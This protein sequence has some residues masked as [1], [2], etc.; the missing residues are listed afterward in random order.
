M[1]SKGFVIAIVCQGKISQESKDGIVAIPFMS[2]YAIRLRNKN[3]RRAVAFVRVDDE[4]VGNIVV[5]ANSF[6]DLECPVDTRKNFK[7]VS[8][9]SGE[10]VDFGKNNK[11]DGSNGV[12]RVEWK[13]ERE[14]QPPIYT[15]HFNSG[16]RPRNWHAGE[17]FNKGIVGGQMRS[18]VPTS[19][20]LGFMDDAAP[21]SEG[22]TV[23]GRNSSQSFRNTHVD[24]EAGE[25][26]IIQLVLKGFQQET[27]VYTCHNRGCPKHT[28]EFNIQ[29]HFCNKCGNR[30][31]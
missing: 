6:V 21:R 9:D 18:A 5:N 31:A 16:N 27:K 25:G 15:Q 29:D 23:E 19:A 8:A 4:P 7:F 2:E 1:Y 17:H 12:I 24:L 30:L 22:C 20:G 11:T 26:V 13:L 14:Y 10:A 28:E 3:N